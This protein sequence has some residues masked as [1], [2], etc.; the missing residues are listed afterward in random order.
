MKET[1]RFAFY[2]IFH[3]VDGF[4]DLKHEQKGKP[5][6]AMTILILTFLAVVFNR[7]GVSFLYDSTY[8]EKTDIKII[9]EQVFIPFFLFCIANFAI[10][11]LMDGEGKFGEI[12]MATGYSLTPIIL[13]YVPVTLLTHLLSLDEASYVSFFM[14]FALIWSGCLIFCGIMSV[15]NYEP[16][17]TVGTLVLTLITMGI[18][19]FICVLFFSL[20]TEIIGFLY[21]I[22]K[23]IGTRI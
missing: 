10:T 19:A 12:I 22:Y 18:I 13:I 20:L 15:H 1:V 11:T 7:L 8:G 16:G 21:T 6:L 9:L 4:W 2:V 17:K 3:P 14:I 5:W 23:E